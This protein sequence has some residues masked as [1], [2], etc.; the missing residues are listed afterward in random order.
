MLPPQPVQHQ[1]A[2]HGLSKGQMGML[3]ATAVGIAVM[4]ALAPSTE[5]AVGRLGLVGL[6]LTAGAIRLLTLFRSR[7]P[8]HPKEDRLPAPSADLLPL[9]TVIV[10][11]YDEAA[12]APQIV[13]A[14]QALRYPRRR[15]EALFVVEADDR[16]TAQ[17][18]RRARLQSWMRVIVAPPGL[19]RTKPRAC[20]VALEQAGGSLLVIFDAEDRPH[21]DQL[22]EAAGR[23]ARGGDR[24]ACLQAPL[25]I[26][27]REGFLPRQFALEYAV[28]FET[29]LPGLTGMGSAV[30]LGGTSNHLRASA[31]RAL[32]GWDA[33][34]VTED[35]DLGFRLAH[36]GLR[37]EMLSLPTHETPVYHFNQW[38]PQRSRWLKGYLQTLIA[39]TRGPEPLPLRHQ[40]ALWATL[41]NGVISALIHGP[42][43]LWMLIQSLLA[44]NGIGHFPGTLD[45]AV[46]GAGWGVSALCLTVGARRAGFSLRLSD[47]L[48]TPLYW[49]MT[50]LAAARA[51]LQL[52]QRPHHWDKTPHEPEA[53]RPEPLRNGA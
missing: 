15:L 48:M 19:P 44:L 14:L 51:I 31:L 52:V 35:A 41:G 17:A 7:R 47:L 25:R 12:M 5:Q 4:A 1:S 36:A 45:L 46:Y 23:F 10:P 49:P 43:T 28:Q 32:G 22:L 6:F 40:A 29:L 34:N 33:Y 30:P 2:R 18:L 42:F 50:S 27:E 9:Y 20:N 37:T 26:I 24:L 8:E 39:W 16:A 21:P 3:A 13:K 38:L 53:L 11:L